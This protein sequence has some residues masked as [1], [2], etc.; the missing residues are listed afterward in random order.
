MATLTTNDGVELYYETQG[1][2]PPLVFVTAWSSTLRFFEKNIPD[3]AEDY[4]VV[5]FD[6]RGHGESERPGHGYRISRLAMDL[7]ELVDHLD[8][9]DVTAVG[10]SMGA[11][12]LWSHLELFGSD[13]ISKLVCI[14][15]SPK[16]NLVPQDWDQQR[17]F[18][19][20][21]FTK[22]AK[23]IEYAEE[24]VFSRM[25]GRYDSLTLGESGFVDEMVNCSK[26][27]KIE[28]M[29]DILNLDWRTFLSEIEIPTLVFV[30]RDSR[31]TPPEESAYVGDQ[32]PNAETVFFDD[33]GHMLFWENPEQFNEIVR[34]FTN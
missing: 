16:E 17:C 9:T 20:E 21:A 25:A 13:R 15:Q 24:D 8:L 3:L 7:K 11:V 6:H 1:E 27:A 22:L 31:A 30:G 32:I 14:D 28:L 4:Q 26:T 10:W 18:D 34:N 2:G 29:R 33:A 12:V 19:V 5:A 23:D